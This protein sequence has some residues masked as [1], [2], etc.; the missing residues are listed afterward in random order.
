M[1]TGFFDPRTGTPARVAPQVPSTAPAAPDTAAPT[2]AGGQVPTGAAGASRPPAGAPGPL[3]QPPGGQPTPDGGR[4]PT[5]GMPGGLTPNAPPP[6]P[7]LG[8]VPNQQNR[9]RH[10]EGTLTMPDGT[11]YRYGTGGGQFA[12]APYGT[13]QVHPG[14]VGSIGKSIGAWA[15]YS[16]S[17][18]PGNN[19][20]HDP[21]YK[22]GGGTSARNGVEIH[23]DVSGRRLIT[24]GC[25]GI[26]RGQSAAFGRSFK[27]AAKQGPL[28]MTI[29]P[30]GEITVFYANAN[31]PA[32]AGQSGTI[33]PPTHPRNIDQNQGRAGVVSG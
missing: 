16:D 17:S 28:M 6:L 15:G 2:T 13:Y 24:N 22:G 31:Q 7:G 1:G 29:K 19:T 10:Y 9:P 27:A 5:N 18:N 30:G 25:I 21:L 23:P 26:D 8:A 14:A 32:V 11:K 12:S 4:A 3:N 33:P 20:V